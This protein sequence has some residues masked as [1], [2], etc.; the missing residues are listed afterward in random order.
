[1]IRHGVPL[2]NRSH[3]P[4]LKTIKHYIQRNSVNAFEVGTQ[5]M[6]IYNPRVFHVSC[7]FSNLTMA[8]TS[9]VL[10]CTRMYVPVRCYQKVST[11]TT[12][13]YGCCPFVRPLNTRKVVASFSRMY[14]PNWS[15]VFAD[16]LGWHLWD[17]IRIRNSK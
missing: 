17:K 5:P 14:Y 7:Y 12:I 13:S 2:Y 10:D 15:Q 9:S 6:S 11:N 1:M 4:R 8:E 3:F 16:K